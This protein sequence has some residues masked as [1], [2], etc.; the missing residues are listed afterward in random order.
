MYGDLGDDCLQNG[1]DLN[2]TEGFFSGAMEANLSVE[3]LL[4]VRGV[5]PYG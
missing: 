2:G 4:T 5:Y 1:G 3:G